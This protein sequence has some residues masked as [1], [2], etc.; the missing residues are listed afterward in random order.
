MNLVASSES[1]EEP[2]VDA[3]REIREIFQAV[4]RNRA[5]QWTSECL[6]ALSRISTV[7][8]TLREPRNSER[9]PFPHLTPENDL[10]KISIL[11][12]IRSRCSKDTYP[13][14]DEL[15]TSSLHGPLL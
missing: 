2:G 12:T 6:S 7:H 3:K 1:R 10:R 5:A 15:K 13:A 8:V 4:Q 9:D 11:L 14:K